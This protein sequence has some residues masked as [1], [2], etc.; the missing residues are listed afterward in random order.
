MILIKD[1]L[2]LHKRSIEDYGGTEGLRDVGLLESAIARPFQ[3][4]EGQDLYP[5]FFEKVAA[6]T[7]SLIANHPFIDGNKRTGMTAMHALLLENHTRL[8]ANQD[9]LYAL[10]IKVSTSSIQF[11]EIVSWLKENTVSF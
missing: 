6:L 2:E 3:M 4:F 7:E 8:T 11:E 5:T 1:I 9:D 10:I